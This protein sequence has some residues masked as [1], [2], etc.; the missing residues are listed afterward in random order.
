MSVVASASSASDAAIEVEGVAKNYGK[1]EALKGIDLSVRRGEMFA[2]LGPNGAGK[3]T[4]FS[5]LATLRAP[6][7]GCARVLGHDVVTERDAVRGA[8]GI[9]FQEPAI[10]QRLSG[11]DN[12]VLM[13]L[14]YGLRTATARQRA[15]ELLTQLGLADAADRPA[16][17]LSGG[18][19]RKLE[20]ARA[21][22]V[23]PQV[24]FLDEAT[25]GL[26]VEARRGFWQQ[27]RALA[28]AGRTVFFT[29]HYMEEAEVAD[30]IALIDSG[31]FVALDTPA[32]LKA[33][34]GGG[35]VQLKCED[36]AKARDWLAA[37]GYAVEITARDGL[38]IVHD[39]PAAIL[40]ELLSKLPV[41]V[42]RV[43][44]HAPGLE[45]VFMKLTGRGLGS[46]APAAGPGGA[47]RGR[48][49]GGHP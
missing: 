22:V 44:V 41:S 32:A 38:M 46:D 40:P 21:L 4:L 47:G 27:I 31:R 17:E 16:R 49:G 3:T 1:V 36:D 2:L 23:N 14:F 9:V 48:P 28:A 26:D 10:E 12:L 33:R 6:T 24:L 25:L 45:D 34:L 30:R 42:K 20:L 35:V 15:G 29:T 11:R 8:M 39:D 43:E 37:R 7:T 5:I 18:Q 19:R 13:G